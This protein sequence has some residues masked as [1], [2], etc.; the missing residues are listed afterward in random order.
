MKMPELLMMNNEDQ[1]QSVETT[2]FRVDVL[3]LL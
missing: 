3:R 2:G 1:E